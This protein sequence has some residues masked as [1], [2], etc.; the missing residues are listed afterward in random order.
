MRVMPPMIW[1]SD[2]IWFDFITMW[3][4]RGIISTSTSNSCVQLVESYEHLMH[5]HVGAIA[6]KVGLNS[7]QCEPHNSDNREPQSTRPIRLHFISI[8]HLTSMSSPFRIHFLE[9][10]EKPNKVL[11][12]CWR[13]ADQMSWCLALNPLGSRSEQWKPWM[14]PH[15][16]AMDWSCF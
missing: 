15:S 11:L 3:Y 5:L 14:L 4:K 10:T 9:Q 16:N 2:T 6:S 8:H 12:L 1:W 7:W 13:N